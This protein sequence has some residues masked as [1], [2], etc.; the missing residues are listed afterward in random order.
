MTLDAFK[1]FDHCGATI[2]FMLDDVGFVEN[3]IADETLF[4]VAIWSR[5]H[6][7][8]NN[9]EFATPRDF[10]AYCKRTPVLRLPV[11]LMD[12]SGQSVNT[13]GF[14]CPWDSGQVGWIFATKEA[15][16]DNFGCK[17]LSIKRLNQTKA[18]MVDTVKLLDDYLQGNVYGYEVKRDGE[19]VDSCWGFYGEVDDYAMGQAMEAAELSTPQTQFAFA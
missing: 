4:Q 7:F 1:A 19:V 16:R 3:P 12:H 2:Q 9:A 14:G 6:D 13:T 5:S 15:L 10:D 11:Y 18:M 8:G 17:R